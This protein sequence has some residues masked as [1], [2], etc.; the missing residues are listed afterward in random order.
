MHDPDDEDGHGDARV[1]RLA[2][3]AG[4]DD[5]GPSREQ[6]LE[7]LLR[8]AWALM[9]KES[10][11]ALMSQPAVRDIWANE[12]H[13]VNFPLVRE[14]LVNQLEARRVVLEVAHPGGRENV[15]VVQAI[16]L[17]LDGGVVRG[18]DPV[19]E[20]SLEAIALLL[21]QHL[22]DHLKPRSR[23]HAF[24]ST[25][26]WD[27]RRDM[28]TQSMELVEYPDTKIQSARWL[29]ASTAL[30]HGAA[31]EFIDTQ[32]AEPGDAERYVV[33]ELET[34]GRPAPRWAEVLIT[35]KILRRILDGA[36]V[37]F[38]NLE[39]PMWQGLGPD[40]ARLHKHAMLVPLA[41]SS[42]RGFAA[43]TGPK[44]AFR[45]LAGT[46]PHEFVLGAEVTPTVLADAVRNP[47]GPETVFFDRNGSL[48]DLDAENGLARH[49]DWV[50]DYHRAR[51]WA[52]VDPELKAEP[53]EEDVAVSADVP[54]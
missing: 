51:E 13:Y 15:A 44:I 47:E 31:P 34:T 41:E 10:R 26:V 8:A 23:G 52:A 38:G 19:E 20:Q 46:E 14:W 25:V 45:S 49:L 21:S 7:T 28:L 2:R 29:E 35:E 54:F 9:D 33:F 3:C 48:L 50:T 39:Q 16:V 43:P 40:G 6:D 27:V 22:V 32:V 4:K 11:D 53:D 30:H 24:T 42:R 12:S 18:P 36:A 1:D 37:D 17:H 5:Q